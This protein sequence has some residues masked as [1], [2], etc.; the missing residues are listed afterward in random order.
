MG[1]GMSAG[2]WPIR[3]TRWICQFA[4]LRVGA[5]RCR[6]QRTRA[7]FTRG[8]LTAYLIQT[9]LPDSLAKRRSAGRAGSS[10][11]SPRSRRQAQ[12][13][14]ASKRGI[15]APRT[16]DTTNKDSQQLGI[17]P[18]RVLRAKALKQPFSEPTGV[19]V[20]TRFKSLQPSLGPPMHPPPEQVIK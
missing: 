5:S 20:A 13:H 8:S 4:R 9:R 11:E 10:A 15:Q 6:K 14:P 18:P 1:S 16:A 19:F 3:Q 12:G 7:R 2:M 17:V